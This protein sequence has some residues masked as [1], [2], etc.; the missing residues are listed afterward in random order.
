M[1]GEVRIRDSR[2]GPS[3]AAKFKRVTKE[4]QAIKDIEDSKENQGH[5]WKK[6]RC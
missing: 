3:E 6:V 2:S 4:K 5:K 1:L